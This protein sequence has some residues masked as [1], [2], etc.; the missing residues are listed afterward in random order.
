MEQ[1]TKNRLTKFGK[2]S[3]EFMI[4]LGGAYLASKGA[5][6]FIGDQLY[7]QVPA[8]MSGYKTAEYGINLVKHHLF[9][10]KKYQKPNFVQDVAVPIVTLT[11]VGKG[12]SYLNL[13]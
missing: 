6:H 8:I 3:L 9:D 7:V 4:E 2:N 11:A 1:A 10:K 5:S 12:L 13:E